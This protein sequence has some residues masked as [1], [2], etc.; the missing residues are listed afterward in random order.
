MNL[1]LDPNDAPWTD[2]YRENMKQPFNDKED[3]HS[4]YWHDENMYE[5]EDALFNVI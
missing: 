1:Y 4:R 2:E 5:Y 3:T